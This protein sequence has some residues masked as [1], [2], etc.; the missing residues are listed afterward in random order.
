[1]STIPP[2]DLVH[3]L[4]LPVENSDGFARL[5]T[6][7]RLDAGYPL[8]GGGHAWRIH[9]IAAPSAQRA[10]DRGADG[11]RYPT[12]LAV[13]P[14]SRRGGKIGLWRQPSAQWGGRLRR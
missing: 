14:S 5:E 3:A 13:K 10:V 12:F 7:V 11:A 6:E 1:V 9:Q 4:V 8:L 2:Q